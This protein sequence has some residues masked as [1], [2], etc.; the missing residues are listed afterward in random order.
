[1]KSESR[2]PS[3]KHQIGREVQNMV[4]IYRM[5]V[6]KQPFIGGSQNLVKFDV[7]SDRLIFDMAPKVERHDDNDMATFDSL[8]VNSEYRPIANLKPFADHWKMQR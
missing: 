2:I 1:M 4:A 7:D 5:H 8:P 3:L 6:G